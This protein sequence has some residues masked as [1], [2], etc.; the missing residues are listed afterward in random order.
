[1]SIFISYSRRDAK[2]V[3]QLSSQLI[4]KNIKVWKDDMKISAGDS[5][6]DKIQAGIKG[7]SYF[8]IVLS[9]NALQSDWVQ[10][11]TQQALSHET[12]KKDIV[13]LPIVIDDC[14]IPS[15]LQDK[16]YVDFR[17][18]FISGF[19]QL[20]SIVEK[21]YNLGDC[22]RLDSDT[23]YYFDYGIEEKVTDGRYFMQLDIVSTDKE[24][25]FRILSQF[26]FSANEHVVHQY[27]NVKKDGGIRDFIFKV[28]AEEFIASPARRVVN[29]K[30]AETAKFTL[31]DAQ[32]DAQIDVKVRVKWL[33][34]ASRGSLLFN[35]GALLIQLCEILEIKISNAE[36]RSV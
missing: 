12:Q 16:K 21:K 31:Q 23:R 35:I 4:E 20:V 30:D 11:E 19:N 27:F 34:A 10:V 3:D 17:A 26:M 36:Q 22:G 1:M 5:L 9:K 24:E 2:F 33:G 8:C 14:E 18:D 32:G 25:A 6:M 13:I 29:A 15:F 7:A 28:C